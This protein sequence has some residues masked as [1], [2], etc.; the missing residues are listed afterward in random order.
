MCISEALAIEFGKQKIGYQPQVELPIAYKG[1]RLASSYR[2]DFICFDD[3][4][5]EIKSLRVLTGVEEAQ[6][7]NYLKASGHKV[8]LLLNFGSA[9]LI[10][11]R[12]VY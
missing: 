12:M 9:W 7:M 11:K 6:L 8:G 2:A 1:Q 10:H 4:I 5:V 3:V